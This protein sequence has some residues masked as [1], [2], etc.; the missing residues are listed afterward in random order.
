MP[1]IDLFEMTDAQWEDGLAMK[2]HGARRLTIRAW[3]A[4]K[5]SRGAVVLISGSAAL[6]PKPAFAAVADRQRRDHRARQ[7]IC[8]AR[9]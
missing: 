3:D 4:L 2:L 9:H 8:R 5:A 6:D 7:G 1:Q